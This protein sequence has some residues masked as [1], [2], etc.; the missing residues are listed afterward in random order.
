MKGSSANTHRT[1]IVAFALLAP[2]WA[3]TRSGAAHRN[4]SQPA[5]LADGVEEFLSTAT[6]P[7]PWFPWFYD[8][9]ARAKFLAKNKPFDEFVPGDPAQ[10]RYV[11]VPPRDPGLVFPLKALHLLV[12]QPVSL[13][14]LIQDQVTLDALAFAVSGLICLSIGGSS[15]CV[16]GLAIY[17]LAGELASASTYPYYYYW[18]V[19]F[20][21]G[22]A[23]ILILLKNS[24]GRWCRLL[25]FSAGL[26]VGLWCWFRGT[27]IVFI[28]FVPLLVAILLADKRKSPVG[29]ALALLAVALALGPSAVHGLADH[30]SMFPR[31]QKWHDLLIGIGTRPNP[32]GIV[33]DDSYGF[34][35]A[36]TKYGADFLTPAYEPALRQEYLRILRENPLLILRNFCWSFI[37]GMLGFAFNPFPLY[38]MKTLWLGALLGIAL[39]WRQ[40]DPRLLLLLTVFSIWCIQLATTAFVE[41]PEVP[42]LWETMGVAIISGGAGFG[43]VF[44]TLRKKFGQNPV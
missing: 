29:G 27:A 34:R 37:D 6:L 33:H 17:A 4:M 41:N 36:K 40:R 14:S 22:L 10:A 31:E 15:G 11:H 24:N 3:W 35:L 42:Y 44:E 21:I 1:F 23:G 8:E 7:L 43:V 13:V 16:I 9:T 18:P 25:S 32:Y 26:I 20:S 28:I 5:Q 30:H 12:G 19:P 38:V 2:F 39:L